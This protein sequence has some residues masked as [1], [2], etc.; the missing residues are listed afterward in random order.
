M[1]KG[2]YRTTYLLVQ[3][4]IRLFKEW[5]GDLVTWKR[6]RGGQRTEILSHKLK[7]ETPFRLKSF[8]NEKRLK[9]WQHFSYSLLSLSLKLPP[10]TSAPTFLSATYTKRILK[11]T[12]HCLFI[13]VQY[14]T[15]S[16]FKHVK[17][18]VCEGSQWSAS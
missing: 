3:R 11:T 7:H 15:Q 5:Y 4:K 13:L 17:W 2:S 8:S 1:N 16:L 6:S 12:F 9:S 14:K 18:I 10:P